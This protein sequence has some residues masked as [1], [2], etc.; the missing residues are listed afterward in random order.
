M[1]RLLSILVVFVMGL[2]WTPHPRQALA[3]ARSEFEVLY[4]GARGGG[5]TDAGMAWM[6][7]PNYISNKRYRG[8]VIRKNSDDLSDWIGRARVFYL[9]VRAKIA[10]NPPVIKFPSG[11]F[12]RTGHLKDAA[13]YEKYQGHEYQK[14][15]LEEATQIPRESDYEKLIS[16]ARSTVPGLPAQVFLTANPGGKGHVW[17]KARFVTLARLKTYFDPVSGSTR[18]FIPSQVYDNPTLMQMDPMYERRLRGI[19]DEKLRKAWLEGNWD[20]FSGQFFDMWDPAV[21]VV[22]PFTIPRGWSKYRMLD[23]GYTAPA[24]VNW[25]AVDYTGNHWVYREFYEKGNVPEVLA[26]KVLALTSDEERIISTFADP[27]IW[28]KNQYGAGEFDEQATTKSIYQ[29]F[30]ECGLYCQKANNDRVSGWNNFRE[31]LSWDENRKPKLYVF[32]TCPET[33]RTL[34]G[35]VHDEND[36]EDLD[37]DGEDHLA[38]AIR[39]GLMHT[40]SAH[41]QSREKTEM[42]KLIDKLH[43]PVENSS[44]D[45]G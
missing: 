30:L 28:A 40:V 32:D 41:R 31:L 5:K 43:E 18:I 37:S 21:H 23:W 22:K 35:L 12:I 20:V 4:G 10:G 45:N 13:A 38:D 29:K 1:V 15:L 8:L 33:I 39:Y 9:P 11:A 44:W 34:P 3:L 6:V 19:K 16:S 36:V 27:S 24:A 2:N 17:V 26:R 25:V 42:E 14:I 7:E